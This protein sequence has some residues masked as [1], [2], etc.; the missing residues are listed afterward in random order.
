[1]HST[2]SLPSVLSLVLSG[3]LLA[4]ASMVFAESQNYF[5]TDLDDA[6]QAAKNNPNSVN[7]V[8]A[9][10][11]GRSTSRSFNFP[12]LLNTE[13]DEEVIEGAMG[14]TA[15]GEAAAAEAQAP[16]KDAALG[17]KSNK[18]AVNETLSEQRTASAVVAPKAP[19]TELLLNRDATNEHMP[20]SKTY[21]V[22]HIKGISGGTI[23]QSYH[24][25]PP[26]N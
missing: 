22:T 10:W 8:G 7:H 17:Y 2:L 25:P 5:S 12:P 4:P 15:A 1:M 11:Y 26:K 18:G 19:K 13:M 14:P 21:G 20:S 24:T 23:Q 3:L 6:V 16:A 9:R